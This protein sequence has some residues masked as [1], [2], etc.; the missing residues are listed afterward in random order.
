MENENKDNKT[1]YKEELSGTP[2]MASLLVPRLTWGKLIFLNFVGLF[3]IFSGPLALF[4]P[5]PLAIS[6]LLY[7]KVK[8]F[9]LAAGWLVLGIAAVSLDPGYLGIVVNYPVALLYGYLIASTFMNNDKPVYGVVK[10][11]FIILG[12]MFTM[13]A[14]FQFLSPQGLEQ[15]MLTFV[16]QTATKLHGS[17]VKSA[18][19]KGEMLRMLQDYSERPQILVDQVMSYGIGILVVT[20]FLSFWACTFVVLRN[21]LVWRPFRRYTHS[22]SEMSKFKMPFVMVWPLIAA[23]VLC[24]CHAYGIAGKW[25]EVVGANVLFSL[26]VFYFFQGIGILTDLITYWRI[27]GFLRTLFILIAVM[28]SFQML[29]V[30]GVLDTWIDFRRF[31][32]KKNKDEGDIS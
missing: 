7:D 18:G 1:T 2:D 20:V 29:A 9:A 10:N 6:F 31:F 14:L 15:E 24:V 32:N 23:L 17:L 13:I 30:V 28:T 4:A 12:L 19:A 21:A 16:K 8:T 22:I 27:Y 26:G 5:I 25:A 11:G 3:L